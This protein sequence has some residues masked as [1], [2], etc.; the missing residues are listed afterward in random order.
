MAVSKAEQAVKTNRINDVPNT[1]AGHIINSTVCKLNS[2]VAFLFYLE[3]NIKKAK[4]M[5]PTDKSKYK[6]P[7]SFSVIEGWCVAKHN[8]TGSILRRLFKL[9]Q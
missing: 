4:K 6:R 1:P 9:P 7:F 2:Q 5:T 8:V 3:P